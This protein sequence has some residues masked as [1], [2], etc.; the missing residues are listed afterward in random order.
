MSGKGMKQNNGC[1]IPH[2]LIHNLGV[3]GSKAF[4]S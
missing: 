4:H 2:E 3:V 1:A